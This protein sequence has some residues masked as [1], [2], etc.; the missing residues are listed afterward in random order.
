[1]GKRRHLGLDSPKGNS[2]RYRVV[3]VRELS[4][5]RR[6]LADDVRQLGSVFA[7]H[8][9]VTQNRALH[10]G[11]IHHG[12]VEVGVLG[13]YS[14]ELLR[15]HLLLLLVP[16]PLL[17]FLLLLLDGREKVVSKPRITR[18]KVLVNRFKL[19][20]LRFGVLSLLCGLWGLRLRLS[21]QALLQ[22]P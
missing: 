18:P 1:M 16:R 15:K 20:H 14:L 3:V 4:R 7:R 17:R 21:V 19:V 11:V 2:Y 6:V 9:G 10:R 22:L 12:C 8:K 5:K 13:L